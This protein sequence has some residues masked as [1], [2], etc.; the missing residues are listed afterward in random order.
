MTSLRE[1]EE[2]RITGRIGPLPK[3][4]V[5]VKIDAYSVYP[6]VRDLIFTAVGVNGIYD[7][8][9]IF[10]G[11]WLDPMGCG[12]PM[13]VGFEQDSERKTFCSLL[14]DAKLEWEQV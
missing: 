5:G 2:N 10:P 13:I 3:G 7:G 9:K 1:L 4:M 14:D 12:L 6:R 11:V 8:G